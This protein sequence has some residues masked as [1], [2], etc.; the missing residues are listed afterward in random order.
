MK[1]RIHQFILFAFIIASIS[2][3][4]P[5]TDAHQI[6][7]FCFGFY[8]NEFSDSEISQMSEANFSKEELTNVGIENITLFIKDSI[9]FM[10]CDGDK[11]LNFEGLMTGFENSRSDDVSFNIL[12]KHMLSGRINLLDRNYKMEQQTVYN[13]E[14]GQLIHKT[15]NHKRYV[16]TLEIINDAN[17]LKEYKKIHAMGQAWPQI[18]RNMKTVGIKDMEIYLWGY[19]AFLIM[20]TKVDFD[21]QKDGELWSTLPREQE[22]QKYVSKFQKVD[23]ESKATEKW[24]SMEK[25]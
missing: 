13:A 9:G 24:V 22:W 18:S 19:R 6:R 14:Q 17:L 7:R 3:C 12:K 10:I 25:L 11:K 4:Q 15:V 23:P 20:D 21:M 16:L 1:N 5:E 2:S 8:V